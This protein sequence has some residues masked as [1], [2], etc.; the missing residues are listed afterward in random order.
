[1]R[2]SGITLE[3]TVV[4]VIVMAVVALIVVGSLNVFYVGDCEVY[5]LQDKFVMDNRWYAIVA[6]DGENKEVAGTRDGI[7]IAAF[8]TGDS[9]VV[10]DLLG[11]SISVIKGVA[12]EKQKKQ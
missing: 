4:A 3:N 9:V 5:T 6:Q 1:M 10:C 11:N 8:D 2:F 7:S 12:V